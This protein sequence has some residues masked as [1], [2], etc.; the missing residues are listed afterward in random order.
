MEKCFNLRKGVCVYNYS[1]KCTTDG[2]VCGMYN[3]HFKNVDI[4]DFIDWREK[5]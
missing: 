3:Q 5:Q 1:K 4:E 2:T